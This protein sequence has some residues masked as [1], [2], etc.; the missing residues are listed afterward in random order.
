MNR[1]LI[2]EN[3]VALANILKAYFEKSN[4]LATYVENRLM[5]LDLML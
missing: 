2:V 3:D 1:V 5:S 4:F